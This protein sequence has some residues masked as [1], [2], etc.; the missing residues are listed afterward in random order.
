MKEKPYY[1]VPTG[2]NFTK[3]FTIREAKRLARENMGSSNQCWF[4]YYTYSEDT[5]HSCGYMGCQKRYWFNGWK[6]K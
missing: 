5:N 3:V 6:W 2:F 4:E 1:L